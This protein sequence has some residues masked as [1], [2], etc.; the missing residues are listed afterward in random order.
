MSKKIEGE[1]YLSIQKEYCDSYKIDFERVK[2]LNSIIIPLIERGLGKT[3]L[4]AFRDAYTD[5]NQNIGYWTKIWK[6][7]NSEITSPKPQEK[8]LLDLFLYL[9]L[10]EGVSSKLVQIITFILMENDH[11]LYDPERREFVKEYNK[12]DK[13]SLSVK[14]QFIEKHGFGLLANAVDK[15][16]RNC[17]AHIDL[18]VNEDGSIINSRTQVKM[19]DLK[20]KTDYLGG[21]GAIILNVMYYELKKIDVIE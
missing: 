7:A 5:I 18:I 21:L 19:R 11:D 2:N 12:L 20:Q 9:L 14:L 4:I 3:A 1:D 6:L 13:I 8:S 16:L 10:V 17:I 15:E